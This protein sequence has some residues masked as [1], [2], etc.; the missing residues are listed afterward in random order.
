M[1]SF[2]RER[3]SAMKK[4]PLTEQELLEDLNEESAHADELPQPL[5][6]ELSPLEQLKGSVKSYERPTDP[7]WDEHVDTDKGEWP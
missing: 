3:E 6:H 2:E 7:V 5:M 1:I 4:K